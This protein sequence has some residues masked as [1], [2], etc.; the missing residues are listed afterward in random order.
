[1]Q[2]RTTSPGRT[3]AATSA[4]RRASVRAT[5]APSV[6]NTQPWRLRIGPDGL[7]LHADPDRRLRVGDPTGRQL[8]ISC[9]CALLNARAALAADGLGVHVARFP[10]PTD[11]TLVAL[12]AESTG[13]PVDDALGRLDTV[14]ELRHSNR[15]PFAGDPVPPELIEAVVAAVAAE[16]A[17]LR[18]LGAVGERH[19]VVD[20][21]READAAS[22]LDPAFLGELKAWTYA[23]PGR[24]DGVVGGI[25]NGTVQGQTLALL[26][27]PHDDPGDWLR[28]GE[29]LERG[30]LEITRHGFVA[31]PLTRVAEIPWTREAL[32]TELRLDGYPHMLLRVGR[33]PAAPGTRRRRLIDVLDEQP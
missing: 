3:A 20:L 18:V 8:L 7:H 32:R 23:E 12:L 22:H 21:A 33:A 6:H 1:M 26:C 14:I 2:S 19:T 11:T 29:G 27:T 10:D 9:G 17:E 31:S 30:L 15:R 13:A 16:G 25:L 5:L 24:V 4:L 28:A